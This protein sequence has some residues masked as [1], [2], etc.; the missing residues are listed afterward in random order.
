MGAI[1]A[2][3]RAV[4]TLQRNPVIFVGALFIALLSVPSYVL[5][6]GQI[7][8]LASAWS[9][10][11]FFISP[12]IMGG[13]IGMAAEGI[14]GRTSLGRFVAAGKSNYLYILLVA[15]LLT[16]IIL[17]VA[18]VGAFVIVFVAIFAFGVSTSGGLD[19]S[20]GAM[21]IVAALVL[22]WLLALVVISLLLQFVYQ[23]IVVDDVGPVDAITQS[24][25]TVRGNLVGAI[26][27]GVITFSLSILIG[28]IPVAVAMIALQSGPS[29]FDVP[30]SETAAY[31]IMFG[32]GTLST[33]VF[34]AFNNT[35]LV[36]F[37]DAYAPAPR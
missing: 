21:V 35:M 24:Y 37:Y 13:I 36:A 7:P 28:T 17:I 15:L 14:H 10:V 4:E 22:L 30:L 20:T 16:I 2:A 29:T 9:G 26:G 32:W 23:A 18:G 33:V 1:T 27:V 8:L 25:R 3:G 19:A 6:I 11:A 5:Q 31:A 34:G 12:F